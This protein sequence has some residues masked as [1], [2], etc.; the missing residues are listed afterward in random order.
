VDYL[1]VAYADEGV[2]LREAGIR[3]PIMV[4]NPT[5]DAMDAVFQFKLEPEIYSFRMLE[6][7][8]SMRISGHHKNTP[9]IHIKVDTGMHRLGFMPEECGMLSAKLQQSGVKVA[10][11]FSHL[12][13]ADDPALSEFSLQQIDRFRIF[14]SELQANGIDGFSRHILNSAGILRFPEAAFEMVRLGI[15]LYGIE[16]NGE[17]QT[18]LKPVSRLKTIISQI[19][20]LPAGSSVGYGRR[21]FLQKESRVATIAIGYSDGFR[22]AF[23]AGAVKLRWNDLAFPVLG[24]VCMDMAMIDVSGSSLQEG[25]EITIFETAEDVFMLARAANTIPYEILTGIGHRVKRI[26]F[27]E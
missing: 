19:K 2:R 11:V 10:T 21:E 17:L 1:A 16:A 15:G 9:S 18:Q 4:M 27:R 5:P 14:C 6:A 23:S 26:F 3:M 24:N 13:C 8:E 12:A 20:T 7:F 25:D 22:R